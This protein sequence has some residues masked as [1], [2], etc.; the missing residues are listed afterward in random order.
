VVTIKDIG[1]IDEVEV[2]MS[3]YDAFNKVLQDTKYLSEIT[4]D[5]LY[6]CYGAAIRNDHAR[7]FDGFTQ[8]HR[9]AYL[10]L[11]LRG[12]HRGLPAAS[13]GPVSLFSD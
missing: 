11:K 1:L 10:R 3:E 2:V 13:S 6:E 5:I 12:I 9:D 8:E 7:P 4:D